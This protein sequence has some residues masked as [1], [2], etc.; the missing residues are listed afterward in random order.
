[1]DCFCFCR[2]LLPTL[3]RYVDDAD[4]DETKKSYKAIR[5]LEYLTKFI[6]RSYDLHTRYQIHGSFNVF[7]SVAV[8]A[9]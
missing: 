4:K 5:S 1:M 8:Y 2:K 3:K 9:L 7:K 6:V